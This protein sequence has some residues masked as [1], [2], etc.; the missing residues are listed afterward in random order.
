MWFLFAS[1]NSFFES[2]HDALGKSVSTRVSALFS[3]LLTRLVILIMLIPVWLILD[4]E[5]YSNPQLW[6]ALCITGGLNV[7]A[8][9]LYEH[10]LHTSDLSLS[11]PMLQFSSVWTLFTAPLINDESIS[12]T[13]SLSVV[14]V[15]GGAYLMNFSTQSRSL[16]APISELWHNSGMRAMLGVSMLWSVCAP[17]DKEAIKASSPLYFLLLLN[18]TIAFALIPLAYRSRKS[19]TL[20]R[21]ELESRTFW[22][23]LIYRGGAGVISLTCQMFAFAIAPVV[24]V[25]T[26]TRTSSLWGMLWGKIYFQEQNISQRFWGAL[27]M[28]V[29]MILLVCAM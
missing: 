6:K 18:A 1:A 16:W 21:E 20:F 10:A 3:L 29:G 28:L 4:G 11:L 25:T 13:A 8:F 19:I 27:V 15:V 26:V 24:A 17:Y 14:I 23:H 22:R 7:I 5:T 12:T 9:L 2:I